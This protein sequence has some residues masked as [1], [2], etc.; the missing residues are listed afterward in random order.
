MAAKTSLVRSLGALP[1]WLLGID[2]LLVVIVFGFI[3]AY[4]LSAASPIGPMA[5]VA[6]AL[7]FP[8]AVLLGVVNGM[9]LNPR[10]QR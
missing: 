6:V 9:A 8:S 10:R 7:C 5:A 4:G 1:R 3:A 2:G